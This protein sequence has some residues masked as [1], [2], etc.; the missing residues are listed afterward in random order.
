MTRLRAI[1][2]TI[3]GLELAELDMRTRGVGDLSSAGK[4]Q[5]GSA[6]SVI[7]NKTVSSELVS[8]MLEAIGSLARY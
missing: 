3:D 7:F 6:D 2:S 8:E 4:R 5:H 1:E